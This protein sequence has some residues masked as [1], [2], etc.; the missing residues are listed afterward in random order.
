M[1]QLVKNPPSM[2]GL[3]FNPWVGKIPWRRQRL[4]TPVFWP[5]ESM[6]CVVHGVANSWTRLS[7]LHFTLQPVAQTLLFAPHSFL[8][9][10]SS[11][12]SSSAPHAHLC[13]PPHIPHWSHVFLVTGWAALATG[14]WPRFSARCRAALSPPR[15]ETPSGELPRNMPHP[16]AGL[17]NGFQ[18]QGSHWIK[19]WL[20]NWPCFP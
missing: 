14:L 2:R 16:Q 1:A 10:R 15:T 3:G 13:E 11:H 17:Q 7:D 12:S 4:P 18:G 8:E 5:G 19:L 9:S 6:D 20:Q